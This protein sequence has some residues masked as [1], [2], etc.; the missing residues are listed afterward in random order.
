MAASWSAEDFLCSICLDV[1]NSPVTTPCGHNFC[2]TCIT[3]CWDGQVLYKCP[4]CN[5][6]FHTRPDLQVNTLL[7]GM[8]DRFRSSVQAKE[9]P[10]VEPARGSLCFPVPC[11]ICT[12]T[13]LKAVKFCLECLISYCQT[14]LKQHQRVTRK[15]KH[16]L[17]EPMD[18]KKQV[19]VKQYT[20]RSLRS[21]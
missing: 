17:V 18:I 9:Q 20:D 3:T 21:R 16:R 19:G 12:G 7:S 15:Q 2:R 11:D 10:C 1:F 14:H 13:R 8:V 4:V 5:N 6:L